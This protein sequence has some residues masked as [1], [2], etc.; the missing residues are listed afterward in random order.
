[1]LNLNDLQV[2][3]G[4]S[5]AGPIWAILTT[6]GNVFSLDDWLV[7]AQARTN[8]L[9]PQ[10]FAEFTVAN[11]RVVIGQEPVYSAQLGHSVTTATV[12]LVLSAAETASW[13]VLWLG[14]YDVEIT[15]TDP[16]SP[17]IYPV[18]S[19]AGFY[20]VGGPTQ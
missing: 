16:D 6:E 5:F 19:P 7:R 2:R 10:V 12:Q 11:G 4:Q 8:P 20:V 17:G 1:M 18:I 14:Q 9:D 13:P 15:S 3:P